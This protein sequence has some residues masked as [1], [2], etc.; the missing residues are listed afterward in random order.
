MVGHHEDASGRA[1]ARPAAG[2]GRLDL[3]IHA[4]AKAAWQA[5]HALD[6]LDLPPTVAHDAQLLVSELVTNSVRHAG[7]GPDGLIWLTADWT[8]TR[9]KVRVRDGGRGGRAAAVAGSIRPAVGAES[10][11]GL[12]L[13]DRLASRWGAHADGYWFE[14]HCD[15]LRRVAT[16]ADPPRPRPLQASPPASPASP[17]PRGCPLYSGG[18]VPT[19][20]AQALRLPLAASLRPTPV[21]GCCFHHPSVMST[22]RSPTAL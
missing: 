17:D 4:T 6:Q 10:G 5:R 21:P 7:L 9:L 2:A 14:L 1:A 11:W 20:P 18:V 12:Y 3:R 19:Q 16:R 13:V 22:N 15:A 8:G